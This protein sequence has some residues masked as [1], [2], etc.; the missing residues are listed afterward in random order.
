MLIYPMNWYQ[1]LRRRPAAR[2]AGESFFA[3]RM[4]HEKDR[5]PKLSCP[6]CD[7]A[8]AIAPIRSRY[9]KAGSVEHDW[10]CNACGNEWTTSTA[11]PE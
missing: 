8:P 7:S 6:N 1:H 4:L 9:R 3:V 11:V 5:R 10:H 2:A